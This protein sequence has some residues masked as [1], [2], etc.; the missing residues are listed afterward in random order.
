MPVNNNNHTFSETPR[1]GE[2]HC[3]I[4]K[5][6]FQTWTSFFSYAILFFG[7][8][9]YSVCLKSCV[10]NVQGRPKVDGQYEEWVYVYYYIIL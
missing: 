10:V 5:Q 4:I 2:S 8:L 7:T 6:E 1:T 9:A 3:L